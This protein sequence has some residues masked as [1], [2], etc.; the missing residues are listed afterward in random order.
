M[1]YYLRISGIDEVL[2]LKVGGV[3]IILPLRPI[4]LKC[5][6]HRMQFHL[7]FLPSFQVC[8]IPLTLSLND[9]L[10]HVDLQI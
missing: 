9:Q 8:D 5:E 6:R 10:Y 4:P 7:V 3:D 2:P 1:R